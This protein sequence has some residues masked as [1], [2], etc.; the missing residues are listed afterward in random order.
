[1]FLVLELEVFYSVLEGR[2]YLQT[3]VYLLLCFGQLL[4]PIFDFR[5]LVDVLSLQLVKPL[6]LSLDMV[7]GV[8]S[9]VPSRRIA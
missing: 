9:K 1:M 8:P 4:Y 7:D 3:I 2:L 5:L 6:E